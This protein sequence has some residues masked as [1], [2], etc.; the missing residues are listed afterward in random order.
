MSNVFAN[1]RE[2]SGKATPN[3]TIAAFPDVCMSPPSPPAGPIPLPYPITGTASDTSDGS[4]T[5]WIGGKEVGKKNGSKYAKVDGNQPA[6][7]S[8]GA[9]VVSH[10]ITGSLKFAAY[11]FDVLFEKSGAERFMDMTIQNDMNPGNTSLGFSQAK[12]EAAVAEA[13]SVCAG[14]KKSNQ[15]TRASMRQSSSKATQEAGR[16]DGNATVTTAQYTPPSGPPQI[17][18]ACSRALA[19]LFRSGFAR[20]MT[21]AEKQKRRRKP[22]NQHQV[23]SAACGGHT[24]KSGFQRPHTSHTEARIIEDIFRANPAGGGTLI[25]GIDWPGGPAAG[26]SRQSPCSNCK[27]LICAAS[28]CMTIKVCDE[29]NRARAPK[30]P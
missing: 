12:A 19:T 24:Y 9:G 20:G 14:L 23:N 13:T 16:L 2:V 4:G 29:N 22:P 8:F 30:C 11:S 10:K 1:G 25:L 28:E 3:K 15:S 21:S 27:D 5:V 17:I 6:T 26:A 7:N 18:R